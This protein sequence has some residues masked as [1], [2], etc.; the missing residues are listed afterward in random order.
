LTWREGLIANSPADRTSHKPVVRFKKGDKVGDFAGKRLC[1]TISR[2]ESIFCVDHG[3]KQVGR[4]ALQ[5]WFEVLIPIR[6]K[7]PNDV[8][9]W[10]FE[11]TKGKKVVIAECYPAA[12]Q[13]MVF[14]KL[15]KKRDAVDV[16]NAL[17]SLA[18]NKNRLLGVE[19]ETWIHAGSSEDEFDMFTTAFAFR[20]ILMKKDDLLKYPDKARCKKL[21]G[22][23]L[24]LDEV[25]VQIDS[26]SKNPSG[27]KK[28]PIGPGS[29]KV[30]K[31]NRNDQENLG[32]S[33]KQGPKGPMY[34]LRCHRKDVK[35]IECGHEHETN[36]QDVFHKKCPQCQ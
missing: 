27:Q 31:L 35:G 19:L 8:A 20:D 3:A 1:D 26:S 11:D 9:V 25:A 15:I 16:S 22:W 7:F 17:I 10:P 4:A 18:T 23:M 30:G 14:G 6:K 12:C 34:R 32:T 36:P 21:E 33:G 2:G 29:P 28:A 5:F 24:G 13:R